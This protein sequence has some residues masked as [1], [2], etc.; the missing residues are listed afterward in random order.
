MIRSL[1]VDADMLY[2]GGDG[3]FEAY[4]LKKASWVTNSAPL[5]ASN[6]TVLSV[7]AIDHRPTPPPSSSRAASPTQAR[8]LAKMS[9][10]GH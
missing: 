5:S 6:G 10:S 3:G 2:V 9:V 1:L 4:D 7:T 8:F